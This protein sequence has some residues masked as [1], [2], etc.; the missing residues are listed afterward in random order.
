MLAALY[1]E[2]DYWYW[3]SFLLKAE[4]TVGPY[5]I[6]LQVLVKLLLINSIYIFSIYYANEGGTR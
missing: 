6:T 5:M 2:E 4:S 1:P 3:Y